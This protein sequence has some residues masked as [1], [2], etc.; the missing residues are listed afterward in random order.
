MPKKTSEQHKAKPQ[1][2]L[3][4]TSKD[5]K[6]K[7]EK[8]IHNVAD[9]AVEQ[10]HQNLEKNLEKNLKKAHKNIDKQVDTVRDRL[11]EFDSWAVDAVNETL[12]NVEQKLEK[13]VTKTVSRLKN[14]VR[15]VWSKLTD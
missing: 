2:K 11:E 3:K 9:I 12:E 6:H 14:S 5:L 10:Y 4:E 13:K 1:D 8:T 7:L 15:S